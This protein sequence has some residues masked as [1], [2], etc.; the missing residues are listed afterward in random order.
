MCKDTPIAATVQ[1]YNQSH[2]LDFVDQLTQSQ[3]DHLLQQLAQVDWQQLDELI[4][5]CDQA[6]IDWLAVADQ[7]QPPPAILLDDAQP[8]ISPVEA[9]A[10][11][12]QALRAG[13][14]GMILVAG[15]QGT[16]LGFDQP[17]GMFPIGPVSGRTLFQMH[18]HRLLAVS[19]RYGTQIPLYIMTSPATDQQTRQYFAQ[20]QEFG[21]AQDQ[22]SIFCQGTMPAVDAKTGK[23]LMES[24]SSLALSPDGHGG[25]LQALQRAGCLQAAQERGIDYLYYAQVDNPLAQLCDPLLMGYHILTGSQMTTQVVQK[26]FAHEKVGNVVALQ[27]RVHIIEYS[28]LPAELAERK[29]LDGR[30]ELWA[31]NIAIHVFDRQFLQNVAASPTGLPFHRAIKKVAAVDW[32]GCA[33]EPAVANA[34]KFERFVFDLLPMADQAIVVEGCSSDVFAPLKNASGAEVDTPEHCQAALLAQHRRWVEAA[35]GTIAP[36]VK[37]EISPT[38]ALDAAEVAAKL[39]E[40]VHF[41]ADTFLC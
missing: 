28:D 37:V 3:C 9:R 2:V 7:I 4:H 13:R 6:A 31:G 32:Q 34:L 15:G 18:C 21:L 20:H 22:V 40:P 29:S 16:R 33:L 11:G 35:G 24:K 26:R 30:L 41:S 5:R 17:K 12:E 8:R 23:V 39:S 10:A 14:V 25:L 1:R 38:W 36:G 27:G 19:R